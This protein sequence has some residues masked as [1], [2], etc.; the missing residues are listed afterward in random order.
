MVHLLF[1]KI[2]IGSNLFMHTRNFINA[3]INLEHE[4]IEL[5]GTAT[6]LKKDKSQQKTTRKVKRKR[7]LANFEANL[8]TL[9]SRFKGL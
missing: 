3:I 1:K 8:E 5:I 7:Q 2:A 4:I 9:Y 6:T